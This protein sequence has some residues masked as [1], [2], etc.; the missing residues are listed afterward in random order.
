MTTK[1]YRA[2][3]KLHGKK[4]EVLIEVNR[5]EDEEGYHYNLELKTTERISGDEFQILRKYLEDEGYVEEA[6]NHK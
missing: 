1:P 3:L 2:T 5:P 6:A 4:Y